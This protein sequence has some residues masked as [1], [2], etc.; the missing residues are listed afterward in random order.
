MI[1]VNRSF[2]I[3]PVLKEG[4]FLAYLCRESN[5]ITWGSLTQAVSACNAKICNRTL[6]FDSL[7]LNYFQEKEKGKSKSCAVLRLWPG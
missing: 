6:L 2:K 1:P 5:C 7:V 4:F 3:Y